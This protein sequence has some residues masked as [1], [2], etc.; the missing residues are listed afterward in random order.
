MTDQKDYLTVEEVAD[1]FGVN[2]T[3]VYR[4]AS[5]K[6]IPGFKVGNQWRFNEESLQA[7]ESAQAS[8]SF[9]KYRK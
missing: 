6:K 5:Q 2:T 4:L 8:Q 1:R 3:T 9:L 7:W